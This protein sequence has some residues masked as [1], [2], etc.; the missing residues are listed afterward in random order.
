MNFIKIETCRKLQERWVLENFKTEYS[1]FK[2]CDPLVWFEIN[3]TFEKLWRLNWVENV[4]ALSIEE[5]IDILP[6]N[7]WPDIL[8]IRVQ[9]S[10]RVIKYFNEY[11]MD[12]WVWHKVWWFTLIKA[13]EKMIEYLLD[14]NL[15]W[16]EKN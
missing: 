7:I 16:Q 11:N 1:Y 13:L 4:P 8:H 14:N 9:W 5:A 3:K 2:N 6:K 10:W 15:I 12:V